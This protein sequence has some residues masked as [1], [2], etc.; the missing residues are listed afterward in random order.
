M[1]LAIDHTAWGLEICWFTTFTTRAKWLGLGCWSHAS[2]RNLRAMVCYL[3][4]CLGWWAKESFL[5]HRISPFPPKHLS[6]ES[7]LISYFTFLITPR[8]VTTVFFTFAISKNWSTML[9]HVTSC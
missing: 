9:F 6:G 1:I 8:C 4:C 2:R 7:M 5:D 3:D